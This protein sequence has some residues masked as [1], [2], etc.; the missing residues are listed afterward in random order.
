M[1][2]QTL[3]LL[4]SLLVACSTIGFRI[5]ARD[6]KTAKASFVMNAGMYIFLYISFLILLPNLGHVQSHIIAEYWWRFL[7]G[8]LSF[9]LTN[10]CTY[11][12]LVYFDAGVATILGSINAFFTIIG[13]SLYLGEYLSLRQL[14]GGIILTLAISY[15]ILATQPNRK[16]ADRQSL[17]SGVMF[18]ILAAIT[19][20]FAAVNEKSLLGLM[21]LGSYYVFGIGGQ[22]LMSIAIAIILQS[23]K[24]HVLLDP[25]VAA[26]C[27]ITGLLRGFG[28]VCFIYAE[29]RSNNVGLVSVISNFKLIIVLLLGWWLLKERK[30]LERKLLSALFAIGG[31]T[32]MFWQ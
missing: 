15:G 17:F 16:K 6:K 5:L 2:W 21:P 1:N 11:K 28:G 10:V 3:I 20:S 4:Q 19:F 26:T 25:K 14:A 13:A 31:L 29:I 9:A 23:K 8:G 30:Y 24:L 32:V 18:A 27:A 22:V 7:L 12:T